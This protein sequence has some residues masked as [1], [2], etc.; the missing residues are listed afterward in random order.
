MPLEFRRFMA[1]IFEYD[2]A[3]VEQS[4]E[5]LGLDVEFFPGSTRCMS[6]FLFSC[7]HG[8]DGVAELFLDRDV[9][10]NQGDAFGQRSNALMLA[11]GRGQ[12]DVIR[13]LL[14]SGA[15][16][17]QTCDHEYTALFYACESGVA[18]VQLLLD[19]GANV[20]HVDQRGETA[21]EF[22][23]RIGGHQAVVDLIEQ[24]IAEGN[25]G[26]GPGL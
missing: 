16:I 13:L 4:I 9:D 2:L 8:R 19:S 12:I 22:A 21:L 11:S 23:R 14:D 5:T 18:A 17:E 15:N 6:A 3:G 26:D 20:N 7:Y 24:H 25:L 1:Q 10:I